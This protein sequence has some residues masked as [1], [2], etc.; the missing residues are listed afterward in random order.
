MNSLSEVVAESITNITENSI[1]KAEFE[2]SMYMNSVD[3]HHLTNEVRLLTMNDFALLKADISR[4][5]NDVDKIKMRMAEE[6]RRVQSNVRL[7]LSLEKGRIRDEQREQEIK[8]TEADAKIESEVAALRTSLESLPWELFKTLFR[9][10]TL[11]DLEDGFRTVISLPNTLLSGTEGHVSGYHSNAIQAMCYSPK[12]RELVTASKD[13]ILVWPVPE[14]VRSDSPSIILP[15]KLASELGIVAFMALDEARSEY[16]ACCVGR[17]VYMMSLVDKNAGRTCLQGHVKDTTACSF[18][19]DGA[20]SIFLISA[21]EDRTF[22]VWSVNSC[23]CIFQSALVSAYPISSMAVSNEDR[24]MVLCTEDAR[25]HIYSLD[26]GWT[27]LKCEPRSL[28]I[29][30]FQSMWQNGDNSAPVS[31]KNSDTK[32]DIAADQVKIVSSLPSWKQPKQASPKPDESNV[33]L[34]VFPVSAK[35]IKLRQIRSK[36]PSRSSIDCLFLACQAGILVLNSLSLETV[37]KLDTS[38]HLSSAGS[39]AVTSEAGIIEFVCSD[40]FSRRLNYFCLEWQDNLAKTNVVDSAG[41]NTNTNFKS[42]V[43]DFTQGQVQGTWSDNVYVDFM[44]HQRTM[45][46]NSDRPGENLSPLTSTRFLNAVAAAAEPEAGLTF[47]SNETDIENLTLLSSKLDLAESQ[48]KAESKTGNGNLPVTFRS[49]VKSSGY[50]SK[51]THMDMFKPRTKLSTSSLRKK[52]SS[53]ALTSLESRRNPWEDIQLEL[54]AERRPMQAITLPDTS[55]CIQ[56]NSDGSLLA[57]GSSNKVVRVFKPSHDKT[58]L[59][60][61]KVIAGIIAPVSGLSWNLADARDKARFVTHSNDSGCQMWGLSATEPLLTF[62]RPPRIAG[63]SSISSTPSKPGKLRKNLSDFDIQS[64]HF[65]FQDRFLLAASKRSLLLASY[66]VTSRDPKSIQP[67]LN[68]NTATTQTV[69]PFDAGITT[70]AAVNTSLSNIVIAATGRSI[71]ICN[72]DKSTVITTIDNAHTRPIHAIGIADYKE[73]SSAAWG[74]NT[75]FTSAIA[76][77]IKGWDLRVPQSAVIQLVGHVNK[78]ASV[79]CSL[80]PC[81]RYVATGSE[82][83]QAYVYDVRMSGKVIKK[84]GSALTDVVSGVDFNPRSPILALCCQDGKTQIYSF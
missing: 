24:K 10:I 1:S 53:Q 69:I 62:P 9:Q 33:I 46:D 68:L 19:E 40:S 30:S 67:A 41:L 21:S 60:L 65:F 51:P 59:S 4:L 18:F 6:L 52:R 20:H 58:E 56:Y 45:L 57:V 61:S 54:S 32:A 66:N 23:E 34:S 49:T 12:R 35:Y 14:D 81:G 25:V 8:I 78:F 26:H 17:D 47:W 76:D 64:L 43:K 22:K 80:S 31:P 83:K 2:K 63:N 16:L 38:E 11:C 15:R 29:E 36:D 82:D 84:I 79:K 72:V 5:N 50:A 73:V 28:K 55:T 48:K 13:C 74:Q 37:F 70:L 7:E 39:F 44:K 71:N 75:F 3:L 77:S 42:F 27:R